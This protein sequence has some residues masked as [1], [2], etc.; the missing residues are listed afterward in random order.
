[1]ELPAGQLKGLHACSEAT[2]TLQD[3][4]SGGCMYARVWVCVHVHA[5]G[6]T[7]E[8]L[9]SSGPLRSYQPFLY[10]LCGPGLLLPSLLLQCFSPYTVHSIV[11]IPHPAPSLPQLQSVSSKVHSVHVFIV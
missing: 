1:M 2:V 5:C 8:F 4:P 3:T 7:H 10:E 9:A 11:T 6:C